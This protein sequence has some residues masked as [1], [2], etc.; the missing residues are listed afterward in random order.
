MRSRFLAMA[1]AAAAV[2]ATT[3]CGGGGG[4]NPTTP[5]PTPPTL[6]TSVI[7]SGS[8]TCS[9]TGTSFPSGTSI[10]LTA[11]P[12]AGYQFAGW[13]GNLSG[14]TNPITFKI[15]ANLAATANFVE[16]QS[17]FTKGQ[18]QFTKGD[19]STLDAAER[20]TAAL[21]ERLRSRA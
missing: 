20:E 12:A 7:G 14:T 18:W 5:P 19:G 4:S 9:P 2:L 17:Q 10:T 3:Q 11:T 16:D 6:T 8:V 1:I 21:I 13:S 15:V